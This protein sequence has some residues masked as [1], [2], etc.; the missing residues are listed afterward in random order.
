VLGQSDDDALAAAD[1]AEPVFV[2][3]VHLL[4]NEFGV[5]GLQAGRTSSMS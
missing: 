1:I 5:V 3:V 4:A 2:L